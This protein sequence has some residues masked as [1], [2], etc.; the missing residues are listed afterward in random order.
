[1]NIAILPG[2]H[3]ANKEWVDQ[4]GVVFKDSFD[5]V[6]VHY[7]DHWDTD[8]GMVDI[9]LERNKLVEAIK[10]WDEYVIV[11]KSAGS[12]IALKGIYEG[13]LNPK[14]CFF[15]GLPY[16][17]ALKQGMDPDT[18]L[19]SLKVR[20]M[21]IQKPYD[22]A[23]SFDEVAELVHKLDIEEYELEKYIVEGEPDNDHHYADVK[24]LRKLIIDYTNEG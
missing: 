21:F 22:F 17:W 13:V 12:M 1:M 7:F 19:S 23:G 24:Y 2:N 15:I 9:D 5:K 4:L 10:G 6:Y 18:W 14:S 11:A 3:K 20:T 16:K 8:D